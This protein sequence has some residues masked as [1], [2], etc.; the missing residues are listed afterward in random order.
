MGIVTVTVTYECSLDTE[1]LQG[2]YAFYSRKDRSGQF[3]AAE[4]RDLVIDFPARSFVS[5][6]GDDDVPKIVVS[7]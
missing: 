6:F 4:V 5:E 7:R 3:T 1:D 2:L